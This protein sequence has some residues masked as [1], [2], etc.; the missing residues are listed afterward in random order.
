MAGMARPW[1][2]GLALLL[3]LALEGCFSRGETDRCQQ[4]RE[5]QTSGSVPSL[6]VP[7]G[8]ADLPPPERFAIPAVGS[9]A[10]PPD[11]CLDRPPDYF[12]RPVA[13]QPERPADPASGP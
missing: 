3:A 2:A 1:A 10:P 13:G 9:G 6:S 11:G 8:L 7:E 5:Y 12:G 4:V